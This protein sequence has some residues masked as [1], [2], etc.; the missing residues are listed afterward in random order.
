MQVKRNWYS[1]VTYQTQIFPL[2]H[3]LLILSN[4][5]VIIYLMGVVM[6]VDHHD[7]S[8]LSCVHICGRSRSMMSPPPKYFRDFKWMI[9]KGFLLEF[10]FNT[11]PYNFKNPMVFWYLFNVKTIEVQIDSLHWVTY[12]CV[13]GIWVNGFSSAGSFSLTLDLNQE[14]S[15]IVWLLFSRS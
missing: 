15:V 10:Y 9:I 8:C 5:H 13:F 3:F 1:D 6:R 12:K 4:L 2:D 14:C 11:N 7:Y